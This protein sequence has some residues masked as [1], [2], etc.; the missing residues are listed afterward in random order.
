[1][2][3]PTGAADRPNDLASLVGRPAP[4]YR[5]DTITSKAGSDAG[6]A[7]TCRICRSEGGPD[8]PLFYPCKCSGSIKYVHQECLMEWL[9]HSHK[10]H[11]ELCKTPFRFTKLYDAN[12]PAVLPW[13]VFVRRA[14][15]HLALTV[16]RA[17]RAVVVSAVWL[18]VLPW[19]IRWSWRWMFWVADVGWA[20]E[21]FVRRMQA[22]QFILEAEEQTSL[23]NDSSL[24]PEAIYSKLELLWEKKFG[25]LDGLH[26]TRAME[27][28]T[29]MLAQRGWN[30]SASAVFNSTSLHPVSVSWPT[31][32]TSMLSGFTY[33]SELTPNPAVNRVIL[34]IF[35]GQLITCV[36]ITGFILVFL[37]REWVVQQQPLVNLD[38]LGNND[39]QARERQVQGRERLHQQLELLDQARQRAHDIE[40]E[41]Q[42]I[43]A[44]LDTRLANTDRNTAVT[45]PQR[46]QDRDDDEEEIEPID[47]DN[48]ES[49]VETAT[50]KY[51]EPNGEE[52]FS[53]AA[54]KLIR[55]IHRIEG[56]TADGRPLSAGQRAIDVILKLPMEQR[57]AWIDVLSKE[58]ASSQ[59]DIM[60]NEADVG[61]P[62][63]RSSFSLTGFD[64][65]EE[66]GD[67][68]ASASRRP[69]MPG[70]GISSRAT[71]IHRS[72]EEAVADSSA[73]GFENPPVEDFP[74]FDPF[75][76][77]HSDRLIDEE[78]HDREEGQSTTDMVGAASVASTESSWHE[79][80]MDV[81][82]RNGKV[83]QEE[84]PVTN[85]GP[86]A[87]INIKRGGNWT[88]IPA[89]PDEGTMITGN[90][91]RRR[92]N[93]ASTSDMERTGSELMADTP[94]NRQEHDNPFHPDGPDPEDREHDTFSERVASVFREE[95]GLDEHEHREH[96]VP[97]QVPEQPAD[98]ADANSESSGE[99]PGPT[100]AMVEPPSIIQRVADWF[101]G[102]IQ[103]QDRGLD[104]VPA[105]QEERLNE[106]EQ[107]RDAPFAAEPN[108]H[109]VLAAPAAID[110]Q[111]RDPEVVAAA[112]QA[113]L[114]PEAIEDAEDLE[115]IF[116]LIGLQGPLIGLFQ[117]SCFCSVLVTGTIIGAVGLPY[118]WGK[119]VLAF[120]GSPISFIVKVPLQTASVAADVFIDMVLLLGGWSIVLALLLA[121]AL[122][123]PITS[124]MSSAWL[125]RISDFGASTAEHAFSRLDKVFHPSTS[126]NGLNWNIALLRGSVFSHNSLCT[127]QREV[128][129]VLTVT[130]G[131]ITSI[132]DTI[133]SGSATIVW[134]RSLNALSHILEIPARLLAGVEALEQYTKPLVDVMQSLR[135]G[136]L[137]FRTRELS[138]EPTLVYWNSTDRSLAV[139]SGYVA[140][141]ALA[142]IYVAL[143]TP[144]TRTQAGQKTEKLVRDTLRQ[145]GGVLKVILIISIEMLVFPLYCGLLLD[146]A[147]LPLFQGASMATR[148]AFAVHSPY[149][150]CFVHWFVGTC[151]MFH[152]A[153]F[154]GM[155]RKILR[156][157]V[158]WFIRDPDDPTFHPV[159]DVLER[160]VTTQLR[161]IAFSALVYGALVILCLGG[162][163]WSIGH[164]FEGI[165][166]IYW[167]ST[168]PV[169]EFPMDL[170]LYNFLTPLL[171]KL[172]KPSDAVHA[173][174]AWWLRRCARLLRLSHFL[175][176]DRRKDEEG[177]HVHKTWTSF[178]LMRRADL[179]GLASS[180]S[181]PNDSEVYFVRDGKYVLTPSSDQ[182]RPPKPGEAFLHATATDA[183]IADKDGVKNE[184][185]TRVYVPPHFRTRVT[186]FMVCLWM[187]SAFTA[188]CATLVPLVFGR[189][190]FAT[191]LARF[192][193]GTRVND[194]YAYSVG[195]YLIFGVLFAA[196]K[197][198]SIVRSIRSRARRFDVQAW[199]KSV[200]RRATQALKCVYVYGF[201]GLVMPFAFALVLQLYFVL[202][203]HTYL[204]NSAA[205]SLSSSAAAVQSVDNGTSLSSIP[206]NATDLF[207]Q[208][209][210]SIVSNTSSGLSDPVIGRQ[211]FADHSIHLLADYA[212]G[213]LY[214][215]I[216]IRFIV[217]A[218][219]SRAAEGLRR[220]FQDGYLNPD[221]RLATRI[222]VL[223]TILAAAVILTVPLAVARFVLAVFWIGARVSSAAVTARL[224]AAAVAA[225][226][227][228]AYPLTAIGSVALYGAHEFASATARWRA[229]IRDE[230]YLVGERL[231]NFGEK[232]PPVGSR[233]V[234]RKER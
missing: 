108:P 120:L 55:G 49:L 38:N 162:V 11:C 190:L 48:I 202:P 119:V 178:L 216:A 142:A 223:P 88:Y 138:L 33:L 101:W 205:A 166:P 79:V 149:T 87:K 15:I 160:N 62:R 113:G 78:G 187:F 69:R 20:R 22:Q 194:I 50:Q 1:M 146:L 140:L 107:G 186:L 206:K 89:P 150:F 226:Y 207:V 154:V 210:S 234:V 83:G 219:A 60:S 198:N 130:G 36:V 220:I 26:S 40:L 114:D 185:F 171:I 12:M 44:P 103:A 117:T 96:D 169:L 129:Y 30:L 105:A 184:H 37:I 25:S 151:Y 203:I 212:L 127:L 153:L 209:S 173:M 214:V 179:E 135:S 134:R 221:A 34:D 51:L 24:V 42:E 125:G 28:V 230:V 64:A 106:A 136:A 46:P 112:Q 172:F 215:R 90:E 176:D 77:R 174:Y 189:H 227:R 5:V 45:P 159:R 118:L 57:L 116:E 195:A 183:Y 23:L 95:F 65:S 218:P 152:F 52:E 196:Y 59:W 13:H 232:R 155:C 217:S 9:S 16:L 14:C 170:L 27:V 139:L 126:P 222:F 100:I 201:L 43:V 98:N 156:K 68:E 180:E 66:E 175:F 32:D 143:D 97:A 6:M 163:I 109:P 121:N 92:L 213:L 161:K 141:A 102:D 188:L 85:A 177:R 70:R 123:S 225:V 199:L 145:A 224:S 61:S 17:L 158:L 71:N 4:L 167:I 19:L 47:L 228:Y 29:G 21:S 53:R 10:K 111:E 181:N 86:D 200:L 3:D 148:W 122:L 18:L 133:S 39:E 81:L 84:M 128:D 76:D 74:D 82:S 208:F 132:V 211:L 35:E 168:E 157:G 115:G 67:E 99:I 41:L 54:I 165:F 192:T 182:Y 204:I 93:Q 147:F 58:A 193:D 104:P 72:L 131:V 94:T 137:T 56:A 80:T 91:L 231:H 63:S 124:L 2:A 144:I 31:T 7:D 229:R 73:F 110:E 8:E 164:I 75:Q 233:S 191:V 197:Y